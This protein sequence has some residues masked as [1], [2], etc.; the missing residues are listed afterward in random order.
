MKKLICCIVTL[1]MLVILAM[2][3]FAVNESG[4]SII[5]EQDMIDAINNGTAT[6]FDSFSAQDKYIEEI[7]ARGVDITR[8]TDNTLVSS[9]TN[10]SNGVMKFNI[11]IPA[12][13]T[14][15]YKVELV[16]NDRTGSID[17]AA[18]TSYTNKTASTVTRTVS[19]NLRYFYSNYTISANYTTG[20]DRVRTIYEC[21]KAASSRLITAVT[22]S[23]FTWDDA[24]ISKFNRGQVIAKTLL[25]AVTGSVD[26]AVTKGI[27]SGSAA[28]IIGVSTFAAD[29]AGSDI[30]DTKTIATIPIKGWGYQIKYE[31]YNG[32]Y[33]R[34]LIVYDQ[35]NKV[36]Q[37]VS[38]ITVSASGLSY[39][40]K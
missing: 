3:V 40:V 29:I 17:T 13:Q 11:K 20:N 8:V 22:S 18:D 26:L 37:T 15:Y 1:S 23:K 10:P 25:F 2:P 16:P 19:V 24:N 21:T 14:L 27:L 30:A 6:T 38:L 35:F 28:T 34:T 36:H 7:E 5:T 4:E 39:V 32:G 33:K 12:G 9:I 31:P